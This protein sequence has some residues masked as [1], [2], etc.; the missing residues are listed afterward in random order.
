MPE[1]LTETATTRTDFSSSADSGLP[2][3]P[4]IQTRRRHRAQKAKKG[5]GSKMKPLGNRSNQSPSRTRE[6]KYQHRAKAAIRRASKPSRTRTLKN[7][8]TCF[9]PSPSKRRRDGAQRKGGGGAKSKKERSRSRGR[10]L[11]ATAGNGVAADSATHLPRSG[12]EDFVTPQCNVAIT[13]K[14]LQ[15]VGTIFTQAGTALQTWLQNWLHRRN[16]GTS[17]VYGGGAAKM[18][19]LNSG[20]GVAT[21]TRP[22]ISI[23]AR[24]ALQMQV[25]GSTDRAKGSSGDFIEISEMQVSPT[26]LSR[27][28]PGQYTINNIDSFITTIEELQGVEPGSSMERKKHDVVTQMKATL[29]AKAAGTAAGGSPSGQKSGSQSASSCGSGEVS[30]AKTGVLLNVSPLPTPTESSA[31]NDVEKMLENLFD[32]IPVEAATTE[33]DLR[34]IFS[35]LP[36]TKLAPTLSSTAGDT[37]NAISETV[38]KAVVDVGPVQAAQAA[39]G[40][41]ADIIVQQKTAV[42]EPKPKASKLAEAAPKVPLPPCM[43]QTPAVPANAVP[44]APAGMVPCAVAGG[45]PPPPPPPPMMMNGIPGVPGVPGAPPPPPPMMGGLNRK[46][47]ASDGPRLR[48]LHWEPLQ[49]HEVE[50]TL[51][52]KAEQMT[53]RVAPALGGDGAAEGDNGHLQRLHALFGEQSRNSDCPSPAKRLRRRASSRQGAT[54]GMDRGTSGIGLESSDVLENQRVQNIS[55]GLYQF[56]K[57]GGIEFVTNTLGSMDPTALNISQIDS[58]RNT[59]LP[60]AKEAE[61]ATKYLASHPDFSTTAYQKRLPP[62]ELFVLS[63]AAIPA[64]RLRVDALHSRVTLEAQI[65]DVTRELEVVYTACSEL[66]HSEPLTALLTTILAVG[67]ALNRGTSKGQ[68]RGFSIAALTQVARTKALDGSATTLLDY[69]AQIFSDST[70]TKQPGKAK[71]GDGCGCGGGGRRSG[72]DGQIESGGPF[73]IRSEI[74]SV[75]AAKRVDLAFAGSQTRQFGARVTE[76]RLMVNMLQG[77][78]KKKAVTTPVVNRHNGTADSPAVDAS[79]SASQSATKAKGAT[80]TWADYAARMEQAVIVCRER[81]EQVL[82]KCKEFMVFFGALKRQEAQSTTAVEVGGEYGHMPLVTNNLTLAVYPY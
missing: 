12:Q 6:A 57:L 73:Q 8:V 68:A 79:T 15:N 72:N 29:A 64:F 13:M 76:L 62:A 63:V 52:A 28:P 2:G 41:K 47:A 3:V 75:A 21:P 77:E 56:K 18:A 27:L 30:S 35:E 34:D 43:T 81:Y 17:K 32:A 1:D 19:K 74:P 42:E 25:L 20:A 80:E 7:G 23:A 31:S 16:V 36:V 66:Q 9:V 37:N 69:I 65:T 49:A 54:A 60:D 10:S 44:L 82:I 26:Q 67:N 61:R 4:T 5:G 71:E 50:G 14:P 70:A 53:G 51:W 39:L 48:K 59:L 55:I 11:S 45:V 33:A 78:E 46:R 22:K 40:V 38:A 24:Q 58:L